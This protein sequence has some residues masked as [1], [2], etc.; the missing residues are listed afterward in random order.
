MTKKITTFFTNSG[1]PQ[2]GLSA[3]IRIWDLAT[4][5]LVVTDAAM[6]EVSGGFY[7][8]DFT[9]YDEEKEYAIRCDGSASITSDGER[10]TYAGNESY[11]EDILDASNN[12]HASYGSIGASILGGMGVAVIGDGHGGTRTLTVAESELLAKAVW[13]F[14]F[15]NEKTAKDVL[16]SRSD[17]NALKDKVLLQDPIVIPPPIDHS[18]QLGFVITNLEAVAARVSQLCAKEDP[19][20]EVPPELTAGIAA[21]MKC[22]QEIATMVPKITEAV[23]G[24]KDVMAL[25]GAEIQSKVDDLTQAMANTTFDFSGASEL[26]DALTTLRSSLVGIIDL[27]EK[28][29][30]DA[31]TKR[32]LKSTL[33][34]LTNLRFNALNK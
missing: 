11:Q 18:A 14:M 4:N 13:T 23:D 8:Y 20:I 6:T 33:I 16:L 27:V 25:S 7:S 9:T 1:T 15:D 29:N 32:A 19:E 2:T 34:Q 17:F 5:T 22:A 28:M 3:T 10:Y 26:A 21:V 12:D 31:Q 24:A 30:S